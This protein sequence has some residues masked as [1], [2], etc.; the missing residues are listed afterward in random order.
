MDTPMKYQTVIKQLLQSY[1]EFL[2]DEQANLRL[3]FDDERGEYALLDFGWR[4]KR[5]DHYAVLH[6]EV[7][8][9][10]I[11]IQCDN[12]ERG[13]ASE[14]VAMGVPKEKIVLGFRQPE[15]RPYTG[16]GVGEVA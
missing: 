6:V 10:K 11:W 9:D 13:I 1:H 16:F 15:L 5:Y 14:F 2:S 12:T 7:I 4:D 8:A 3:L